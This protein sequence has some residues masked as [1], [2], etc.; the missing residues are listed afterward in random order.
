MI[1]LKVFKVVL[2]Y[3]GLFFGLSLIG[4]ESVLVEFTNMI[5]DIVMGFVPSEIKELLSIL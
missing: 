3:M 4:Q 2:L 1:M 5:I